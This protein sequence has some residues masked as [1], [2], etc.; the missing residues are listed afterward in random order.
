VAI[1]VLVTFVRPPVDGPNN[2]YARPLVLVFCILAPFAVIAGSQWQRS[3]LLRAA[4]AIGALATG[5]AVVGNVLQGTLFWATEPA[6]VDAARWINRSTPA[7][8]LVAIHPEE[9][10][11]YIGF[12]LRRPVVLADERHARLLGAGPTDHP[13][14]AAALAEAYAAADSM[15]AAS[16]FDDLNAKTILVRM[17]AETIAANDRA[18]PAWLEA[19]CFVTEYQNGS[20]M[21][22]RRRVSG[23]GRDLPS[24]STPTP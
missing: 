10:S 9:F 8:D 2:L 3:K 6:L 19:P 15:S 24:P 23:C 14:V 1:L 18:A 11:R 12:W 20:W 22:V 13:R 21:V 4:I 7:T 16:R 5:Y 17:S